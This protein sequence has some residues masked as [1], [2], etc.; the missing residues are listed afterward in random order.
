LAPI[1][2]EVLELSLGDLENCTAERIDQLM[3]RIEDTYNS[4]PSYY[5]FRLSDLQNPACSDH[6]FW[7]RLCLRLIMLEHRLLLER[8]AHKQGFLNGQ[9]MVNCAHE[10][11]ELTVL[12][13]VQRDRFVEHHHDYDWMLMCWGVPSS[14]VLCV[15]LLKQLRENDLGEKEKLRI[16]RSEIVQNLSLLIGF[17]EWVKP[18]A[19]NYQLCM[20]MRI[21]IK[22]ILDQILNPSPPSS[23]EV[24]SEEEESRSVTTG[25]GEMGQVEVQQQF[26]AAGFYEGNGWEDGLALG[27]NMEWL[28]NMDWSRGPWFDLGQD[29]SA[30]RWSGG[31]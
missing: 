29:F 18:A 7:K 16:P 10:M 26:D 19:G 25:A 14:G 31:S 2:N 3:K 4:Y 28:N 1:L 23:A 20:R 12:I 5:Q 13:W 27:D 22:R 11:L 24:Q 15:E 9:T 6:T 21:I 17:L 8:L 30:A